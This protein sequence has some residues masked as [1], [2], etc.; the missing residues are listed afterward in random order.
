MKLEKIKNTLLDFPTIM[1]ISEELFII[2]L[3]MNVAVEELTIYKDLF[4][5]ILQDVMLSH[6]DGGIFDMTEENKIEFI[7]FYRWLKEINLTVKFEPN[8]AYFENW[9]G[10]LNLPVCEIRKIFSDSMR[11]DKLK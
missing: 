11:R 5:S 7:K 8:P 2:D 6:C 4:R 10:V 9:F 1:S 3:L